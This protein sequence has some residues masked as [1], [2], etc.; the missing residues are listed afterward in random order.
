MVFNMTNDKP[1]CEVEEAYAPE[2]FELF[3]EICTRKITDYLKSNIYEPENTPVFSLGLTP[4][5]AE[6]LFEEWLTSSHSLPA[7]EQFSSFLDLILDNSMHLHHPHYVGHQVAPV[8]PLAAVVDMLAALL[9]NSSVVFE[10]G[11]MEAVL[12]KYMINFFATRLGWSGADAP[13]YGGFFTSGGSLGNLSALLAARNKAIQENGALPGILGVIV[14]EESHYSIVRSLRIMG[15]SD[16][17][18]FKVSSKEM[19]QSALKESLIAAG[20]SGIHIFAVVVNACSTATGSFDNIW[21]VVKFCEQEKIWLHVDA[22]HGGAAVLS[23]RLRPILKGI[24]KADSIII[25]A[26]KM[27]LM[28][29]LL[30]AVIFRDCQDPARSCPDNAAFLFDDA[31]ENDWY[32]LGRQTLECTKK[33][34]VLKLFISVH[35]Y[36]EK[37]FA[38]YVEHCYDLAQCFYEL[39]NT[40][41]Q[42]E[43]LKRPEFN[44]VCF[45]VKHGNTALQLKIKDALLSQGEFYIVSAQIAG[46]TYLRCTIINPRTTKAVLKTLVKRVEELA[47][48]FRHNSLLSSSGLVSC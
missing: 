36:G 9:N 29:A 17:H 34:M 44:I 7:G 11:P 20:K 35:L 3:A 30:T 25:D 18:I 28:P 27:M 43:A 40:H 42:L 14:S 47:E 24:E 6:K 8:L 13:N 38:D 46:E 10:M 1:T 39:I 37:F 5:K 12:E 41:D 31:Q 2:N 15:I 4:Q 26:H 32:T 48:S 16:A 19:S 23:D 45:R 21:E 33:M 22:A